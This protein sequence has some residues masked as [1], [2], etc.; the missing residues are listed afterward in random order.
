MKLVHFLVGSQDGGA[1]TFFMKLIE[2]QHEAGDEILV[3]LGP[4][5]GRTARLDV[6]GIQYLVLRFEG[7]IE[8]FMSRRAMARALLAFRPDVVQ[9]WMSRAG[10]RTRKGPYLSVGR[11]GGYYPVKH[12]KGCDHLVANTP[13]IVDFIESDG[14]PSDKAHLISNFGSLGPAQAIGRKDLETP[15]DA[16][17]LLAMGRLDPSKG[18]DVLLE[19]LAKL[20]KDY[21]LWLAGTGPIEQRLKSQADRLGVEGRVRF[22]GWRNDTAALYGQADVYVMSSRDEPLGNVVLE[23]WSAK[24]PVVAAQSRGPSWII[25]DREDG[26][27]VPQEDPDAMAKSIEDV[28]CDP[29]LREALIQKA[30]AVYEARFSKASILN[31]YR[32][33]YR[34]AYFEKFGWELEG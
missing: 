9:C 28:C 1:E 27:M 11:Q 24:V 8:D 23:A 34:S 12:Y 15:E 25:S 20:P 6:L 5:E 13:A 19:A 29:V 22:L 32:E 3:I 26:L 4:H 2:A 33:F 31:Q 14:W 17:V 30:L 10:R 7:F 16:K 21:Y 18:F